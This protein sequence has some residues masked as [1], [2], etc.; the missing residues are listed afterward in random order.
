MTR[1]WNEDVKARALYSAQD[2]VPPQGLRVEAV[3]TGEGYWIAKLVNIRNGG[4]VASCPHAMSHLTKSDAVRCGRQRITRHYRDELL[5]SPVV[6]AI[7]MRG[8]SLIHRQHLAF[9]N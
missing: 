2:K 1:K 5:T 3:D 9:V 8:L 7:A 4:L 6:P